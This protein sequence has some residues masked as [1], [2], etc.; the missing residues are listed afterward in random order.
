MIIHAIP[1]TS[2]DVE[3]SF[4]T[5]K[6]VDRKEG[7]LGPRKKEMETILCENFSRDY[8]PD[9]HWQTPLKNIA[10]K[11]LYPTSAPQF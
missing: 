4:K 6:R 2:V 10:L 8:I 9:Y 3:R 11:N 1:I 5:A 7:P